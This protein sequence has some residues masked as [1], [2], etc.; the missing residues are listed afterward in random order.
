MSSNAKVAG[1]GSLG[2]VQRH[3]GIFSPKNLP[4]GNLGFGF[5]VNNLD[6][7]LTP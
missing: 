7:I 6:N 5:G 4:S 3:V 1:S 2:P